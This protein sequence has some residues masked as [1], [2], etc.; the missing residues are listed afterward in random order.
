MCLKK[1]RVFLP[2]LVLFFLL[3]F[4]PLYSSCWADVVLSDLEA[5][6]ILKEIE[7]SKMELETV[8]TELEESKKESQE[9]REELQAVKSTYE[10]QKKSYEEQ[11]TEARKNNTVAWV[12]AGTSGVTSVL[13]VVVLILVAL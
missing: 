13:L 7:E 3:P 11:L 4:S 8:K 10:E 1:L 12:V 2:L 6:M 5:E 9:Q